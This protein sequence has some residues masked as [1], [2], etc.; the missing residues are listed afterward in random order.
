LM[1]LDKIG[2]DDR[3]ASTQLLR[4]AAHQYLH[5][6]A[7]DVVNLLQRQIQ[8]LQQSNRALNN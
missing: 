1:I 5:A 4:D 2:A 6:N 7:V 3:T 8:R